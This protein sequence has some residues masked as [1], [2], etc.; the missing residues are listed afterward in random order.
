MNKKVVSLILAGALSLCTSSAVFANE[1]I[2][3]DHSCDACNIIG[4][5][6]VVGNE[7]IVNTE[8][9]NGLEN[10]GTLIQ[11]K[12]YRIT[13][14]HEAKGSFTGTFG[15]F[16]GFKG[17]P[18]VEEL[19]IDGKKYYKVTAILDTSEATDNLDVAYQLYMQAGNGKN[20]HTTELV[21][22]HF[23]VKK[24]KGTIKVQLGE[25]HDKADI[26]LY[27]KTDEGSWSLV[28]G[29]NDTSV[30]FD[31]LDVGEYLVAVSRRVK[32]PDTNISHLEP[33]G[34]K[35]VTIEDNGNKEY[36]FTLEDLTD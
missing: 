2:E 35:Y 8:L 17:E 16:S 15:H 19:T 32:N 24:Q 22:Y 3:N 12:D 11:G 13:F 34:K 4:D 29:K 10:G 36:N 25:S 31:D 20:Y 18:E 30:Q 23:E 9:D 14:I 27:I 26:E 7:V 33:L 5:N 28:E 1:I 6:K 21:N